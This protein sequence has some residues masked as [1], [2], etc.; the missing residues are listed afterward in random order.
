MARWPKGVSGNPQGRRPGVPNKATRDV[1]LV[2]Q[3]LVGESGYLDKVRARLH[4]GRLAPAVELALW[5]FAYGRPVD[6]VEITNTT[7][8][9]VLRVAI[10]DYTDGAPTREPEP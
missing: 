7:A 6:K 9:P 3:K 10:A 8:L 2:A 1:R 4:A 5:H